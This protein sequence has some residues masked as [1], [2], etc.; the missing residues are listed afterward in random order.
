[1]LLAVML[2]ITLMLVALAIEAPRIAQQ[3]QR[4][5]E[6][7]LIHR[8]KE[9]GIAI[10]KYYH[11]TGTYPVSLDQLENTNHLRFLRRRYKD[12]MTT[13][14]EWKLIHVGEAQI[15]MPTAS[16]V[17]GAQAPGQVGSTNTSAPGANPGMN[18][19]TPTSPGVFNSGG[20]FNSGGFNQGGLNQGGMN[21]GGLN[22]G[23]LNAGG[24]NPGGLNGSTPAGGQGVAGSPQVGGL[25]TSS[26]GTGG[27][28]PIIGVASTSKGKGIKEF[29]GSSE[30]DNWLFVYDPRLEQGPS[31]GGGVTVASPRS[32]TP[33]NGAVPAGVVA[34]PPPT[35]TPTPP[36][37]G[38]PPSAGAGSPTPQQ[39]APTPTPQT[40]PQ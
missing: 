40:T 9:Y 19:S 17:A 20:G 37:G 30:Y 34:A 26:I 36:T 33:T 4:Q 18:S 5:K 1:M 23:G 7:E 35:G 38:T 12:P 13:T 2:L 11:K 24:T 32:A 3:I 14:G 27:G 39:P 25:Q 8:G 29:N 16:G 22:S 21:P 6:E 15:T 28:G 31:G 10:K